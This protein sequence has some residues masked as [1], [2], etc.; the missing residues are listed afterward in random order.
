MIKLL[1][2]FY[3]DRNILYQLRMSL[4]RPLYSL[5]LNPNV[6]L[7]NGGGAVLQEPLDK[8]NIIPILEINFCRIPL[9]ETMRADPLIAQVVTD[10]GKDLLHFPCRDGEQQGGPSDPV[11]QAVVLHVL[12][13]HKGNGKDTL[14]ARLLFRNGKA[15]AS[16]VADN[17][18]K[19]ESDN[20]LQL[21]VDD[22]GPLCYTTGSTVSWSTPADP[23]RSI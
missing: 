11:T 17:V 8:G 5:W 15:V 20:I 7:R 2:N 6:S 10:A 16:A 12:I 14:L 1:S 4:Y 13:N 3:Q 19:T 9:P 22:S 23:G 21:F 18:G